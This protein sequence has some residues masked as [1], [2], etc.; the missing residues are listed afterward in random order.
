MDFDL[1]RTLPSAAGRSPAL[2]ARCPRRGG[3]A[4]ARLPSA[5]QRH[6]PCS[7]IAAETAGRRAGAR[8]AA[9]PRHGAGTQA[10]I[11]GEAAARPPA[12]G[13]P[14]LRRARRRRARR[15]HGAAVGRALRRLAGAV[16]AAAARPARRRSGAEE[17]RHRL[18]ADAPCDRRGARGSATRRSCWSA[19]RPTTSASASRRRRPARWPCPDRMSGTASWRW[20]WWRAR[21]TARTGVITASG[22]RL[23]AARPRPSGMREQA[24]AR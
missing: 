21:S 22:R 20:N 10:Q 6:R 3:L 14:G 4:R 5:R 7:P 18:R 23:E 11:V 8:S 15:R 16:A 19:T 17:C 1:R 2:R 13:R 9:R 12:V 24:A